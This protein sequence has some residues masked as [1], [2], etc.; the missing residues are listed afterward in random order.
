MKKIL[1]C[2]LLVLPMP[3]L[4]KSVDKSLYESLSKVMKLKFEKNIVEAAS[5][6]LAIDENDVK[7]LNSL[8]VFY[9]EAKKYNMAKL[10]LDRGIKAHPNNQAFKNNLALVFFANEERRKAL[11]SLKEAAEGTDSDSEANLNLTSIFVEHR[12]YEKALGPLSKIYSKVKS[13]LKSKSRAAVALTNN[14]AV[15]L[16]GTKDYKNAEKVFKSAQEAGVRDT[17]L[18]YNYAVFMVSQGK[19]KEDAYKVIS[20]LKFLIEDQKLLRKVELLEKTL[21]NKK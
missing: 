14:Y 15:S 17:N 16:V 7:A 10:I 6:I 21:D 11:V 3:G 12:D 2:V 4:A 8:A 1:L 9:Y 13:K 20:R 18:L 19:N 5:K